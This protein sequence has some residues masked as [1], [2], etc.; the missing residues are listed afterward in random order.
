VHQVFGGLRE[1]P[2]DVTAAARVVVEDAQRNRQTPL[3]IRGKHLERSTVEVEMPER[4]NVRGFIAADLSGVAPYF[5]AHFA[6][7]LAATEPRLAQQAMSLH[8]PL[9]RGIGGEPS[10]ERID[11]GQSGE[12]VVVKLVAPVRVIT[13]VKL[14]SLGERSRQANLPAVLAY[15]AAQGADWVVALAARYVVPSGDGVCCEVHVASGHRM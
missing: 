8:I 11:L 1:I 5:G 14:K 3:A 7:T 15:G 10:Q 2:L 12:V 9:D 6:G 13:V 4:P